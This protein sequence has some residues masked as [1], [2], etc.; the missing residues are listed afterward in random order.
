[1]P[2][3]R[4]ALIVVAGEPARFERTLPS[5]RRSAIRFCAACATRLFAE[6]SDTVAVIRP[7]TLDDT[8]W[9]VPIAQNFKRS[10]MPWACYDAMLGFDEA[11]PS[12]AELARAWQA[13]GVRFEAQTSAV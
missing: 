13:L 12:F 5:G 3:P 11:P 9:V 2:S 6:A 7:G 10:A 8:R 1:M 4:S